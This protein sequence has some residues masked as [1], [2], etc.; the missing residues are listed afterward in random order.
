[1]CSHNLI[2]LVIYDKSVKAATYIYIFF[3]M[4]SQMKTFSGKYFNV[5]LNYFMFRVCGIS[6]KLVVL[7]EDICQIFILR[8]EIL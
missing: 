6:N 7:P 5:K 4:V 1:M 2:S 8:M 3:G